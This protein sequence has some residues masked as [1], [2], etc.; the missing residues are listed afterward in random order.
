MKQLFAIPISLLTALIVVGCAHGAGTR[1]SGTRTAL[2]AYIAKPDS[3]YHYEMLKRVEGAGWT[4]YLLDMTSQSW[5]SPEE[6]DRVLWQHWIRII[7]PEGASFDTALLLITGG[8]NGG[9]PPTSIDDMLIKIA[10]ETRT[11]VV[12]LDM[13]PNQPLTFA[14]EDKPMVEDEIIAYTWEK[15]LLTGDEEWPARLPMTKSAVRAMDAVQDFCATPEGGG[16]TI[17]NFVVAG[18]SKRGWTTWTVAATDP[19]VVAICPIV[20]DMLN[21]EPSFR[22]HW[23]AY[24]FWAPAVGNY[25]ERGLMDWMGTP[26]Y[27]AL[28]DI[29]EPYRYRDRLTM[30]KLVMNA[31]GDQ[32]FVSDSSQFYWDDLKGEKIL[33]YVPNGDHGLDGTDAPYTLGAF[34]QYIL[35][36]KPLPRYSWTFPEDGGINVVAKDKPMAVKVWHATNP[37]ARDFSVESI[38]KVWTSEDIK[39][40]DDGRYPVRMDAPEKGW[41]AYMVELTYPGAGRTP[42]TVTTGIRVV[43]D[44]LPYTYTPPA[45]PPK[46]FMTGK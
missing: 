19:R 23:E 10:M 45:N 11:V 42:L 41:T 4:G 16:L 20:I 1:T 7:R 30:P 8:R 26:E 14:D 29:V 27:D 15:F 44:T 31:A 13:V 3:N 24:G 2:D 43:P 9:S 12:E 37:D 18:G 38:G 32:F 33:R 28:L 40:R 46:G 34:L 25:A 5:R 36:K 21:L 6:V 17:R 35:A 22:H 39:L